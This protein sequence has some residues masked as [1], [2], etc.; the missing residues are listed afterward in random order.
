[1]KK[2]ADF[3]VIAVIVAV[4]FLIFAAVFQLLWNNGPVPAFGAPTIGYWPSLWILVLVTF[5]KIPVNVSK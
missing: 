5:F 3:L 2:F 4:L 1:M